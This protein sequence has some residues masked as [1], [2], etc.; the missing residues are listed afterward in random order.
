MVFQLSNLFNKF[1]KKK[2][3]D[4][5]SYMKNLSTEHLEQLVDRQNYLR[6]ML[7]AIALKYKHRNWVIRR[8]FDAFAIDAAHVKF[9]DEL[10]SVNIEIDFLAQYLKD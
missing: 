8:E 7:K 2:P 9:K 3:I 10:A 5:I 1:S 6:Y 4:K